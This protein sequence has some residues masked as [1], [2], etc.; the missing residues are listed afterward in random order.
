[1]WCRAE[2]FNT[3]CTRVTQLCGVTVKTGEDF[4]LH[5]DA[6]RLYR[7][8]APGDQGSGPGKG[9]GGLGTWYLLSVTCRLSGKRETLCTAGEPR[10][11]L[12]G[13][14]RR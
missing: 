3:F 13:L 4:G 6:L 8:D 9:T 2:V 10:P 12:G 1:M 14:L 5:P 11:F 7:G